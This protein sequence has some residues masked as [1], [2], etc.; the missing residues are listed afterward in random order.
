MVIGLM[1]LFGSLLVG[2]P[3]AANIADK[4]LGTTANLVLIGFGTALILFSMIA[5]IITRLYVKTKASEA[6][7]RTG[8]GGKKVIL[9]GGTLFIP[10]IHEIVRV[11]LR[12]LKLEITSEDEKAM[13]TLDKLRADIKAEFFV[14]VK[15]DA[16]NIVQAAITIGDRMS[17]PRS[18]MD[19]IEDK[20]T[21]ALGTAAAKMTLEDLNSNRDN[22]IKEVESILEADLKENGFVLE[23]VTISKLDQT[24]SKFLKDDNI[25]DAQGSKKIA[26]ITQK[27]LTERNRLVKEGEQARK[28]QDVETQKKVLEFEQDEAEATAKQDAEVKK[29]QAVTQQEAAEKSIEAQR[30]VELAEVAKAKALEVASTQQKQAVA[31]AEEAKAKAIATASQE[32]AKAESELAVAQAEREQKQQQ[33]ETV[34][35]TEQAE[36]EKKE[37]IIKAEAKA[38]SSLVSE[39]KSADAEAYKIEKDAEARKTAADADAI[40]VTKKAEAEAAA[41]IAEARAEEAVQMVPVKVERERVNIDKDRVE[42]VVKPE[43]Q[44]REEFGKVAQDF[45]IQKLSVAAEKEIR[46]ET[47]RASV[48]LFSKLEGHLYGT[49]AD[50]AG[51]LDAVLKGQG[52][53]SIIE[54]FLGAAGPETKAALSAIASS[55]G[56]IAQSVA[57]RLTDGNGTGKTPTKAKPKTVKVERKSTPPNVE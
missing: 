20:L 11:S 5:F 52:G 47:A 30:Q 41:K 18:V 34:K 9:D 22:F 39:Q 26:E 17:D 53:A 10:F 19:L 21:S 14:R 51:I 40:A 55:S 49:P 2:G 16:E 23:S 32:K 31:V 27:N 35:V 33:I 7:V 28:A 50:A 6:F 44:A 24:D 57:N 46:I 3:I 54:G 43:L 42:N 37:M 29:V 15:P 48:S 8:Q 12:S 1:F 36:R 56:E 4:S 13:I 45:E 25:F 38:E